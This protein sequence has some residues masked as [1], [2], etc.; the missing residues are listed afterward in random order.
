[1]E[2]LLLAVAAAFVKWCLA[3][4]TT[5]FLDWRKRACGLPLADAGVIRAQ[6]WRYAA[7]AG[8]FVWLIMLAATSGTHASVA[9]IEASVSLWF[10]TAAIVGMAFHAALA[11]RRHWR[12]LQTARL[13][14]RLKARRRFRAHEERVT[15]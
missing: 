3:K 6:W 9:G 10:Q 14:A 8:L 2:L 15:G 7:E 5:A 12:R 4:G 1:M 11:A 13:T